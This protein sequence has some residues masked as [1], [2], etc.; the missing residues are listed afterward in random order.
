MGSSLSMPLL[1]QL[2]CQLWS[3]PQNIVNCP[4][5]SRIF[6]SNIPESLLFQW[7]MVNFMQ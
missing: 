3:S 1:G 5:K 6:V 4:S 7:Q 2:T